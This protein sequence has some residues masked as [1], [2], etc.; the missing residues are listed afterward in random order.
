MGSTSNANGQLNINGHT[1]Q[2]T[3][4]DKLLYP[5]KDI[6]K[7]AYL[8]YLIEVHKR[9]L[10]F[11]NNRYLTVKRYP[12]GMYD[13]YF[14][15][16]NCPDYA[17]DFIQTKVHEKINYIVCNDLETLIWLG[18]QLSLEFHIP[19]N[20]MGSSSPS[21]IVFD[22]DP[23]SRDHFALAVQAGLEI[24]K[25]LDRFDLTGFIKTSGNKGLQ[26]YIP[27][28]ED[29]F[30]YEET[31]V[32][33]KF[34]ADYLVTQFPDNFTIERLKENRGSKCYIDFLQHAEGKT[35][36]A[37]YSLRGNDDALVATPLY[38]DEVDERLKPEMFSISDVLKRIKT[39]GCPFSEMDSIRSTQPLRRILDGLLNQ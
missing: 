30:V 1:I 27:I 2:V 28:P 13:D 11:L 22:L 18:N 32:F 16:K 14:Y 24:K 37:P 4:L 20:K 15:Q 9:M 5:E 12:H 23:P 29:Q 31:R 33:T 38:W 21:E 6:N 10:P 34:I 35:I 17:P 3:S 26:I 39:K 25:I 7:Q 19:F 8:H 36:I